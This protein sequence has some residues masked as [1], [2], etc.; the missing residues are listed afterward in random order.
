MVTQVEAHEHIAG[1]A[2]GQ[3]KH[4]R[5]FLGPPHLE[6][7]GLRMPTADLP[8]IELSEENQAVGGDRRAKTVMSSGARNDVLGGANSWR[9]IL[10]CGSAEDRNK[11][12]GPQE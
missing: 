1:R 8:V 5:R 6:A 11:Q 7:T 4:A 3:T 2:G 10:R 9:S 12:D